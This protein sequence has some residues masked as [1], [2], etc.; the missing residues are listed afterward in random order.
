MTA[1]E[2]QP[3][4][5]TQWQKNARVATYSQLSSSLVH[6]GDIALL[7]IYIYSFV[8]LFLLRFR[9]LVPPT[10]I[11]SRESRNNIDSHA[12]AIEGIKHTEVTRTQSKSDPGTHAHSS[13][14][15]G[16]P[17]DTESLR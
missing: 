12:S 5:V 11:S 9:C 10:N 8:S 2:A 1:L 16:T 13:P 14:S 15:T 7:Y 4:F 3:L 6:G 17:Q